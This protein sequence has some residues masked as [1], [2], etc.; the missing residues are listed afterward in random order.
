MFYKIVCDNI[1][2]D[3]VKNIR[4]IRYLTKTHR[5]VP[6]DNSSAHGVVGSDNRTYY[7]LQG[8]NVPAVKQHWPVVTVHRITEQDF[9]SYKDRLKSN[10]KVYSNLNSL[11][12][13]RE[14]KIQELSA[15]CK[16]TI[17]AGTTITLS[18]NKE[19]NF[20]MTLEDQLNL[21]DIEAAINNGAERVLYHETDNVCSWFSASDMRE[22][23]FRLRL[24]KNYHTTYFN[25]IKHCILNMYSIDEI[26]SLTYGVELLTLNV[27][28]D[29]LNIVKE[30][31]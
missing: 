16:A 4:Y 17:E 23:I 21:T 12:V 3:V 9:N 13:V 28:E 2:V 7:A 18:D 30:R 6:T 24:H 11:S 29:I 1:V 8:R 10:Q 5:V 15:A 14:T 26:R 22:I 20:R 19:H 31:L 25:L 27:S